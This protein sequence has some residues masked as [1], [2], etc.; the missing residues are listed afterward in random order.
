MNSQD[1]VYNLLKKNQIFHDL[2]DMQLTTISS[3]AK[4]H[5]LQAGEEVF[6]EGDL[7]DFF[8]IIQHGTVQVS[9]KDKNMVNYDI[10]TLNEGEI[11]GEIGL[12][13]NKPRSASIVAL[14]KVVLLSFPIDKFYDEKNFEIYLKLA[15][16]IAKIL[17][18]RLDYTYTTIVES[19]RDKLI[20]SK[21]FATYQFILLIVLLICLFQTSMIIYHVFHLNDVLNIKYD[22]RQGSSKMFN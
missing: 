10:R 9:K 21:K 2:T 20:S 6:R 8:Y 5:I 18:E 16:N 7:S 19:M 4:E 15:Q 13:T 22:P 14:S 11:L 12:I 1:E 3:F 17:A